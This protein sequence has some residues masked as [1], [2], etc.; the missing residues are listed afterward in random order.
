LALAAFYS[1][2]NDAIAN[3]LIVIAGLI[4]VLMPTIWLDL[5]IGLLIFLLNAGAAKAVVNASRS[6]S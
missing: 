3:V 6:N 2:R 5:L 1:A 4:T